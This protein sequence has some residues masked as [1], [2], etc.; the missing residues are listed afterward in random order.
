MMLVI[1]HLYSDRYNHPFRRINMPIYEYVC[2][3]CGAEFDAMRS[4]KDADIE[5]KCKK[6]QSIKTQRKLS[7]FFASSGGRQIAGSNHS[8][9][10]CGGGNCSHCNN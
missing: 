9:G 2:K 5:I 4:M 6:C 8:C 10:G 1:D 3:E 7:R